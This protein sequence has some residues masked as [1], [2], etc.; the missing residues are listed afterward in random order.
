M[1]FRVDNFCVESVSVAHE[2]KGDVG[3]ESAVGSRVNGGVFNRFGGRGFQP[4][5]TEDAAKDPVISAALR[6]LGVAIGGYFCD[7]DFEKVFGGGAQF[8]EG[9]D[10][11][12]ETVKAAGVHWA[13]ALAVHFDG[14]VGHR[15]FKHEADVAPFP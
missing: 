8:H 6:D 7:I 4:H 14:G 3:S 13:G 10:V 2:A 1:P 9:G 11:V 15:A 12:V 5:G